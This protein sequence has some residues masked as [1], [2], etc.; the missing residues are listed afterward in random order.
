MTDPLE[1]H[2]Q[3]LYFIISASCWCMCLLQILGIFAFN[4]YWSRGLSIIEKRYP[5]LI[6]SEA[7]VSCGMLA[8]IYPAYLTVLYE[9][10][11]ISGEWWQYLWGAL[12]HYTVQIAPTIET[13]RIWLISYDLHFLHS[14]KNQQWKTEIDTSYA[15]KDWYLQNRGKWGNQQYMMKIAFSY[16]IV[17]STAVFMCVILHFELGLNG[18]SIFVLYAIFQLAIVA[19]PMYLYVR[20][21]RNLQD[22][23]LFQ[24]GL[25]MGTI[26]T[27]LILWTKEF[28]T[29]STFLSSG[30]SMWF[31]MHIPVHMRLASVWIESVFNVYVDCV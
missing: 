27:Y 4:K 9:Y 22:Q 7:V 29:L 10:P 28:V 13:C 1:N 24:V 30:T 6:M 5:R 3:Q 2:S 16:Y 19:V 12:F 31:P 20:T 15:E 21:P 18:N 11:A 25:Q 8:L 14:S 17:T 23:F 26:I